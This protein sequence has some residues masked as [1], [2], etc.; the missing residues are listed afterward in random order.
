M[1]QYVHL[2]LEPLNKAWRRSHYAR[3]P[4]QSKMGNIDPYE[5]CAVVNAHCL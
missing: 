3:C 5:R 4:E 2:Y 1:S